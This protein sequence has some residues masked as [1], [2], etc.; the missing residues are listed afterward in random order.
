MR[1]QIRSFVV[2][3]AGGLV[4]CAFSQGALFEDKV[5]ASDHLRAEQARE[6][7]GYIRI[8]ATDKSRLSKLFTPDYSSPKAFE[9]SAAKLRQRFAES[10][11]YPPPGAS[12]NEAPNFTK[13][14]E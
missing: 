13:M 10:I 3:I 9:K 4:S 7:D 2:L 11:G 12:P 6:L 14:G 8:L 1:L 5:S